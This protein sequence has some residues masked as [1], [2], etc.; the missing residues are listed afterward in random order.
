MV[1]DSNRN[2]ISLYR[3][4]GFVEEGRMEKRAKI[5]GVYQDMVCMAL[6][7]ADLELR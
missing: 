5:N 1:Y 3:A 6:F 4:I 7:K 2:A